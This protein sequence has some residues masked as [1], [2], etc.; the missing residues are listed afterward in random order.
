MDEE[1]P[2]IIEIT[3]LAKISLSVVVKAKIPTSLIP[4]LSFMKKFM[5]LHGSKI[6]LNP[7]NNAVHEAI[8][9]VAKNLMLISYEGVR[10]DSTGVASPM[11][12]T[13]ST[14]A[15]QCPIF[16]LILSRDSQ[17]DGEVIRSSI[18]AAPMTLK[19]NEMDVVLSSIRFLK[20]LVSSS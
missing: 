20:E 4:L 9:N 19:S 2:L 6:E 5:H 13:L 8:Q 17:P 14:C 15:K 7:M 10:K 18:E 11:F 1:L 3:G 12:D 16:L